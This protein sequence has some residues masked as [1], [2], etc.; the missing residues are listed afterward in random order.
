MCQDVPRFGFIPLKQ[1]EVTQGPINQQF[2]AQQ[3]GQET[4][5]R[6]LVGAGNKLMR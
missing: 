4:R 6:K 3:L 1:N 5:N 2:R